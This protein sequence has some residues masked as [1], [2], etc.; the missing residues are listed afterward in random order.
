[1]AYHLSTANNPT[2][3]GERDAA[4]SRDTRLGR[5]P[6]GSNKLRPTRYVADVATRNPMIMSQTLI[7]SNTPLENSETR[8]LRHG[9]MENF[10]AGVSDADGYV[11][12]G[13]GF[14]AAVVTTGAAADQ[15][16]R[17]YRGRDT[18]ETSTDPR[19]SQSSQI[20][21]VSHQ[22]LPVAYPSVNMVQRSLAPE[23]ARGDSHLYPTYRHAYTPPDYYQLWD[24]QERAMLTRQNQAA[25]N[26]AA[27]ADAALIAARVLG[28]S[29]TSRGTVYRTERADGEYQ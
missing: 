26:A 15:Q 19:V 21:R 7:D 5:L 9:H 23:A 22:P 11:T 17:R 8:W 6:L 14:P 25:R 12:A 16:I 18:R 13:P 29:R 4:H 10:D 28:T 1:M 27:R 24:Y 20:R 2:A 3:S